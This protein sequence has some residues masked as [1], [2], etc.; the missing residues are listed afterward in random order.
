MTSPYPDHPQLRGNFAPLRMECDLEDLIV[1]GEVPADLCVDYFRNGPDP[2]YPPRGQHHWFAGDGML[3]AF[4]VADGRIRY[5]NR[6]LRTRKWQLERA[7]GRALF[8]AFDPMAN[9]PSVADEHTD[10]LANTNVV[11]HGDRLLA[12]E[13]A[14]APFE[15][16]PRTLASIGAHDYDGR[17]QGPMTAHPKL[18]PDTGEM[19]A[20]GYMTSGPFSD[21]L[22]YQVVDAAGRMQ[23]CEGFKAPFASMMHDFMVTSEHVIFPVFP[24]TGSLERAMAG[25]PPFAWEPDKGTH[26]GVMPRHGS[27]DDIRW[28]EA[29]PCYVFHPMNAWTDGNRITAHVMQFEEAPLFPRADGQRPDP[30]KANARL[31]EWVIDLGDNAGR[32]RQ[33]YLDDI[34]GEFPRLDERFAGKGYRHGY[35]GGSTARDGGLG[36]D[37]VVHHDFATGQRSQ[38]VLPA[39]DFTGEPVFVPRSPDAAEGDG[40]LISLLYRGAENR[41][42][43]AFFDAGDVAAGPFALGQL[44]HRVPFGFHGN[45]RYGSG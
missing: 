14:H 39:G 26:V 11:W 23:R 10:G 44:P 29:D 34:T 42:D 24:L 1:E 12:L 40:Y 30:S 38:Y 19:L 3:H 31:C 43:L 6:W 25:G 20:F 22:T 21:D 32:V 37:A 8:S 4:Y 9:D 16:D 18:D 13:E 36:F 33:R 35:Y 27:T 7:A 2:Q 28:F 17:L 41:S 5:R 45:W 15:V